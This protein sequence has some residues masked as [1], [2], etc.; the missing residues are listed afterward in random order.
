MD[1]LYGAPPD[2]SMNKGVE[3]LSNMPEKQGSHSTKQVKFGVTKIVFLGHMFENN[4]VN[5]NESKLE[6][7]KLMPRPTSKTRLQHLTGIANY[8]VPFVFAHS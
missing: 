3:L 1:I 2:N 6:A 5:L 4:K 7:V 8:L